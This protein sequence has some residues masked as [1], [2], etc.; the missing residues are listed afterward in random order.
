MRIKLFA[1]VAEVELEFLVI[2]EVFLAAEVLDKIQL[3]LHQKVKIL[4][5][6]N[7]FLEI[8][9]GEGLGPGGGFLL[10]PSLL[11]SPTHSVD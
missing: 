8:F 1:V 9:F 3:I 6:F 5:I 4:Q 10:G 11:I 2:G 7:A